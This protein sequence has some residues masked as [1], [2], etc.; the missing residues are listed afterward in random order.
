MTY[1]FNTDLQHKAIVKDGTTYTIYKGGTI[2]AIYKDVIDI[3]DVTGD[4]AVD[5][6]TPLDPLHSCTC[7]IEEDVPEPK[8]A[9]WCIGGEKGPCNCGASLR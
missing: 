6:A 9:D 1:K 7:D 2:H 8:H 3:G 4:N 5:F